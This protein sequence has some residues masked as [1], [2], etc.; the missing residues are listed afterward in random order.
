MRELLQGSAGACVYVRTPGG[1]REGGFQALDLVLEG[2]PLL[3][4]RLELRAHA[5]GRRL[6]QQKTP[7]KP[8]HWEIKAPP[9]A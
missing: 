4:Q 9:E 8:H 3:P 1:V 5:R 2:V 7:F 6:S